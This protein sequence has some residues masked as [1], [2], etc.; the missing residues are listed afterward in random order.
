M[1]Y[2]RAQP[3]PP[4]MKLFDDASEE[5]KIWGVRESSLGA[6][7]HVPHRRLTWEGWEDSAVPP[8]QLGNYL[9]EFLALLKRHQ[10]RGDVY[11]HF[12]QGCLHVRIDYD[13]RSARGIARFH[14]F[15]SAAADLVLRFGGSLSGEHGDGQSR[16]Q[17]LPRM[18]GPEL[19]QAFE[20]FKAIWDPAW[21]MNPGKV[22][23]PYR[24]TDNLRLG[25]D[26]NP[27]QVMTFFKYLD[28]SGDFGRVS[29]RCVGVGECRRSGKGTMCPSYR[30]TG[31]EKHSTRGRARLLF[32][33]LHG[34]V[35]KDGWRDAGV[36]DALHLCLSCKGCKGECPV[37]VDMATYKAEFHAHFYAG[38]VRPR[39]AYVFGLIDRWAW[40]ASHAPGMVNFLTQT[41]ALSA[42]AKTIAGVARE[43]QLPRL[44]PF[45]FRQWFARR[46]VRNPDAPP[47]LLWPDTFSNYFQPHV[48][49]AAVAVLEAAG[50]RV[51]LPPRPLC[52]GRPLYDPGM[53]DLARRRLHAIL[54]ALRAPIRQG[55]PMVGLEPACVSVFRD[56][57][58]NLLPYEQDARR[59]AQQTY[60]LG[61]FLEREASQF[62]LPP[63]RER[64]IV[65]GHCHHKAIMKMQADEAV[66]K[67]LDLDYQMLDS[68]CCG[69][70]GGFGFEKDKYA[71]S[72]KIGEQILLPA[73]RKAP[74]D[75][76]IVADGYSCRE[77]IAQTTERTA[78]HL[79]ELI[80]LALEREHAGGASVRRGTT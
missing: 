37:S 38:R 45:T 77:Q 16:A 8:D 53:L 54:A 61:E 41:P 68:G 69:M 49:Q 28:D 21:K 10:Y 5:K 29:L 74:Q 63:L 75:T 36:A 52:C 72:L 19:V 6:T 25:T 46:P 3:A 30:A 39:A 35:I 48:A 26:Y 47:V 24:Q 11:G 64:A 18:F 31:E 23:L 60:L 40:L 17:F 43:R 2:L 1:A 57:M 14:D 4:A 58:L 79:A 56:E 20:R 70:A 59:L 34:D 71:I 65:H 7:A 73:V 76:L 51:V 32:E 62:A 42:L 44:S 13:L 27:P 22:V 78:L 55:V 67:R 9:R 50:R 33:M 15:V 12:G 80:A 66:F